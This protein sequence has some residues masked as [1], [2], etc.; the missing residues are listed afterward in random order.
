MTS[1]APF[2]APNINYS[3]GIGFTGISVTSTYQ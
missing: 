3:Y 1:Y 2:S